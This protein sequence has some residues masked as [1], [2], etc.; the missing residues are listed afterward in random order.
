M[1]VVCLAA[2]VLAKANRGNRKVR[3]SQFQKID[4]RPT[5]A[6]NGCHVSNCNLRKYL[7]YL[8]IVKNCI[9]ISNI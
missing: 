6:S 1:I 5:F 4:I 9:A 7:N 2:G 3:T 8:N